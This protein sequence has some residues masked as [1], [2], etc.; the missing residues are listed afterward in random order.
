MDGIESRDL[1]RQFRDALMLENLKPSYSANN[2]LCV[3]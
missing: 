3:V 2:R 1:D